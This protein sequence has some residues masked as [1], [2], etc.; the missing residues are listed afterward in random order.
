M[1][2]ADEDVSIEV[3]YLLLETYLQQC[4]V[5]CPGPQAFESPSR[6]LQRASSP[7]RPPPPPQLEKAQR[8]LKHLSKLLQAMDSGSSANGEDDA[9]SSRA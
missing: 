8:I 2:S 4:Q 5:R 1:A 3:C 6:F 9:S 7:C